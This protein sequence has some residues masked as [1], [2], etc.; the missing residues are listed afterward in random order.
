MTKKT[1]LAL[2]AGVLLGAILAFAAEEKIALTTHYPS[3]RGVYDEL[4]ARRYASFS[5]PT[6][7]LLDMETG[8]A[9]MARL[10]LIDETTGRRY[11]LRIEDQRLL[12]TDQESDKSFILMDLHGLEK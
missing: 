4:R 11:G 12:V 8:D 2:A 3:P 10:T 5:Q 7:F 6:K 1:A 9:K